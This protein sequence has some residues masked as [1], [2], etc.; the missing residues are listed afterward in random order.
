MTWTIH[1]IGAIAG[2]SPSRLPIRRPPAVDGGEQQRAVPEHHDHQRGEPGDVD[3]AVAVG[4]SFGGD[5]ACTG[6]RL[7]ERACVQDAGAAGD[8]G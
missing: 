1:V 5:L 4:R 6:H 3:R 2:S 8:C 7:G